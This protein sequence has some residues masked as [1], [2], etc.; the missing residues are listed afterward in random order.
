MRALRAARLFDGAD[1][2]LVEHPLVLIEDGRIAAVHPGR[3]EPPPGTEMVDL[4]DVT[5]LPG[6]IDTHVHLGFDAGRTPVARM[7]ADDDTVLVLR[8][9]RAARR[10]L[11]AGI[12]TVRDLGDRGYLGLAL[13]DWFR[14]G[15]E[16][17]PEIVAAGPPI[18]VTGGHCHFMGGEADGEI[19]VRRA[20]R[21]RVKQGVDVIKIM[22]TGGQMTPGTNPLAAQYTV[23]ELSAA[24]E[25]A[26]RLGRTITAHAH[27]VAGIAA[28]VEAGV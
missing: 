22:A 11:A 21:A 27:G 4:G 7:L 12:T 23:A 18:T 2:T 8:M 25:E 5:L 9:R 6:L 10:A 19:E 16:S 17:G 20:V 1:P 28:A 15:E 14:A 24:A 3:R 13:R 26:H